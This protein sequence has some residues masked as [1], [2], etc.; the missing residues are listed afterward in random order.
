MRVPRY[1]F[2]NE[3]I[4]TTTTTRTTGR[5]RYRTDNFCRNLT[6]ER[7]EASC[8]F[9]NSLIRVNAAWPSSATFTSVYHPSNIP[10]TWNAARI[11]H[12]EHTQTFTYAKF[13]PIMLIFARDTCFRLEMPS[14]SVYEN[15]PR[16]IVVVSLNRTIALYLQILQIFPILF[17][18]TNISVFS[19]LSFCWWNDSSVCLVI[20]CFVNLHK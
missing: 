4:P 20:F 8:A 13:I 14:L 17:L 2:I 19:F 11:M 15:F 1:V 12:P 6:N 16:T 18:S 3:I 5:Q 10:L 7:F 9:P